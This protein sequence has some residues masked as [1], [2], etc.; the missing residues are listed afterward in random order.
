MKSSFDLTKSENVEFRGS[1]PEGRRRSRPQD[2]T[3]ESAGLL[4]ERRRAAVHAEGLFKAGGDL[5]WTV[6]VDADVLDL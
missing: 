1:L 4:Q 6:C 2:P 5:C 3:Q